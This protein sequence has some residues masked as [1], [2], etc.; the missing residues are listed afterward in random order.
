MNIR[1][2][3]NRRR[4]TAGVAVDG[5]LFAAVSSLAACRIA[6]ALAGMAMK[7]KYPRRMSCEQASHTNEMLEAELPDTFA[8]VGSVHNVL[9]ICR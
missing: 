9:R 4:F 7:R 5:A 2:S 6:S 3:S 8:A 1:I